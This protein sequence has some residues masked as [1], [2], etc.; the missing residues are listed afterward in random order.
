MTDNLTEAE[1]RPF[2]EQLDWLQAQADATH[3]A[4]RA[5]AYEATHALL[6]RD[7]A[8]WQEAHRREP[9]HPG[10]TPAPPVPQQLSMWKRYGFETA[11]RLGLRLP[12][13]RFPPVDQPFGPEFDFD[14]IP[15][16]V[17]I[18]A[19]VQQRLE[20]LNAPPATLTDEQR[21]SHTA[22]GD[23]TPEQAGNFIF[24]GAEYSSRDYER[25]GD[26]LVRVNHTDRLGHAPQ[27]P[28]EETTARGEL[29]P[30]PPTSL[31]DMARAHVDQ[32]TARPTAPQPDQSPTQPGRQIGQ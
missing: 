20:W 11:A 14:N 16:A 4:D 27:L 30:T 31:Q 28:D 26:G 32:S 25:D 5:A 9:Q 2:Q 8:Q 15:P 12:D 29:T 7:L 18:R 3:D 22:P 1:L 19:Q 10:E 6:Q 23:L 24:D 13:D 21:R 17:E